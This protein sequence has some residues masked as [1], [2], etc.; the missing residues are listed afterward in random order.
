MAN[1]ILR[2]DIKDGNLDVNVTATTEELIRLAL[3]LPELERR[4]QKVIAKDLGKTPAR[5]SDLPAR[6]DMSLK[7]LDKKFES[8]DT[9]EKEQMLRDINAMLEKIARGQ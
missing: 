8:S 7:M 4:L 3:H 6:V 9:D 5:L 2:I 1:T